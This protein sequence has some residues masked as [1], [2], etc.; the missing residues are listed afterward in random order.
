M[1]A[2]FIT[3]IKCNELDLNRSAFSPFHTAANIASL[4]QTHT[5]YTFDITYWKSMK[6]LIN[7][8]QFMPVYTIIRENTDNQIELF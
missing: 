6:N 3:F 5:Y 2:A 4:E 8:T 1:Q 7:T